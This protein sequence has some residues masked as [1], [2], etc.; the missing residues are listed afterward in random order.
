MEL[1]KDSQVDKMAKKKAE[2]TCVRICLLVRLLPPLSVSDQFDN[3]FEILATHSDHGKVVRV[4]PEEGNPMPTLVVEKEGSNALAGSLD[5][6]EETVYCLKLAEALVKL[7]FMP[8]F[9]MH[10]SQTAV[11]T[12][13]TGT[14]VKS[15]T[16]RMS[17]LRMVVMECMLTSLY[18]GETMAKRTKVNY[19]LQYYCTY[20]LANYWWSRRIIYSLLNLGLNIRENGYLPY[21][22]HLYIQDN[23]ARSSV[24]ALNLLALLITREHK[25]DHV[26]IAFGSDKLLDMT[27][28]AVINLAAEGE[29]EKLSIN[30]FRT[31]YLTKF[32]STIED[33]MLMDTWLTSLYNN[34]RNP[35][36]SS[37]T[38]LP[39]SMKK[40]R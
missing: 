25:I 35:L 9:T 8:G 20:E 6:G 38:I 11:S 5:R 12:L 19:F 21:V 36:D 14:K 34:V 10:D 2:E 15:P 40:V 30:S 16:Q 17:E 33:E 28:L 3:L 13:W 27:T 29:R 22:S 26:S 31:D 32:V 23:Q 7:C 37:N 39:M 18:L 1:W 24:L 4:V